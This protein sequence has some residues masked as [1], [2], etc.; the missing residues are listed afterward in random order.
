MNK[1]KTVRDF[2][3]FLPKSFIKTFSELF[4]TLVI[5]VLLFIQ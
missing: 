1:V 3:L 2:Y 4:S 5:K